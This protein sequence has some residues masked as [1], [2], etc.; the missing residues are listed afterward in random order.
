MVLFP[1]FSPAIRAAAELRGY[2]GRE[3]EEDEPDERASYLGRELGMTALL[4]RRC[5]GFSQGEKMK[6]ALA[7]ALVRCAGER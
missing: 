3:V 6:A 7:R 5:D 2:D 1:T 4:D